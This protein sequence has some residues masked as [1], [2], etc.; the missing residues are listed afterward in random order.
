MKEIER[1]HEILERRIDKI[2]ANITRLNQTGHLI[3][4]EHSNSE[5]F[6]KIAHNLEI[7]VEILKKKIA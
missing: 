5:L 1:S 7:E 3:S 6:L 4:L 2:E